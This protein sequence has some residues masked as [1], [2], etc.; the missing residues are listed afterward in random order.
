VFGRR[1][2]E[3][4]D[5]VRKLEQLR[6]ELRT[7]VNNAKDLVRR[8]QEDEQLDEL[9]ETYKHL[10]VYFTVTRHISYAHGYGGTQNYHTAIFNVWSLPKKQN[11]AGEC[12][13]TS[14]SAHGL[15]PFLKGL[16]SSY[17]KSE[18]DCE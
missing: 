5:L 16:D 11:E 6:S 10:K 9:R 18:R 8:Q 14:H 15:I 4:G 13:Y 12:L 7:E 1:N 3:I 17:C 2:N